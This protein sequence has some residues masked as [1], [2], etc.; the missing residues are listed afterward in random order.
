[1]SR[2]RDVVV[3]VGDVRL[4]G[5]SPFAGDDDLET[6]SNVKRCDWEFDKDA[7]SGVSQ[8]CKD[9]ICALLLK[10]PQ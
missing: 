4:S 8:E 10:Q 2:D 5:L 6:L 1:M 3:V 7:F 9:F